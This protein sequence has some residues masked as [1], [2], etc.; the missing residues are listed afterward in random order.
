VKIR[1][2]FRLI[3]DYAG[4]SGNNG[5]AQSRACVGVAKNIADARSKGFRIGMLRV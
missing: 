5:V 4:D 2:R 3:P 1:N